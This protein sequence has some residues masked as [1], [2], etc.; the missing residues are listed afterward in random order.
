M[1]NMKESMRDLVKDKI[2][3]ARLKQQ[4]NKKDEAEK[5]DKENSEGVKEVKKQGS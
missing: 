5:K 2:E 3:K 1:E 4:E